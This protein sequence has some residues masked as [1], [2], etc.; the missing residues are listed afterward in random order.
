M[1]GALIKKFTTLQ[2]HGKYGLQNEEDFLT[3]TKTQ[4]LKAKTKMTKGNFEPQLNQLSH[5]D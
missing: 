2:Q 5:K 1:N 4:I 3:T